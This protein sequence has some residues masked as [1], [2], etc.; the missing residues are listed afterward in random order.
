MTDTEILKVE[1]QGNI[2]VVTMNRPGKRN[3]MND[4]LLAALDGFFSNPPKEAKVVVLT[5]TDGHYCSGL[6]LSEHVAR[7]AEGTMR[8]SRNWHGVMDKIQYGGLPVVSA[9]FGAAI[10]G[11]LELATS[12]HVRIAEPS[13]IFQLPEGRRGIYVGGGASV[14][15]GRILGADR[16]TEMMLTGRKYNADEGLSLGLA[17]YSVG[18]GEA[19]ALALDLARK[20]AK[21]AGLSNYVMIHALARIE[22]MSKQDGLF[23]ESLCA[24][25]T[26]TSPDAEEGLR[27]F[28]DKR[29][30]TFR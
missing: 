21:N 13:T 20:I 27:A 18:E 2:A 25:L 29:A 5:G 28:L 26:Q 11:G 1:L 24:A 3:A 10:G 30:P 17:H 16:M 6:D 14:R 9:I 15:V 19:L 23:T 4:E 8:H 7:D 12:T 22:D